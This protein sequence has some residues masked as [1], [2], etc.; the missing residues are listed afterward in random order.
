MEYTGTMKTCGNDSDPFQ[1]TNAVY[2]CEDCGHRELVDKTWAFRNNKFLPDMNMKCPECG[3][4]GKSDE[5][6]IL[7]LEDELQELQKAKA[8]IEL[9][10]THVQNDLSA[11]GVDNSDDDVYEE[12]KNSLLWSS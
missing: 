2:V 1:K 3:S 8:E 12:R 5:A 6:K 10:I 7:I 4:Y 11:L 9:R